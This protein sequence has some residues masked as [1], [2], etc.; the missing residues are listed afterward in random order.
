MTVIASY[1]FED[2]WLTPFMLPFFT[3]AFGLD[4]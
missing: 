4:N 2:Q 3:H 1:F